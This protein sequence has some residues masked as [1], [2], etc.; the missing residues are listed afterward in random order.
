[1]APPRWV[2]SPPPPPP[3][4]THTLTC[5]LSRVHVGRAAPISL[6]TS[7]FLA[8][9]PHVRVVHADHSVFLLPPPPSVLLLHS[10]PHLPHPLFASSF[11]SQSSLTFSSPSASSCSV[12]RRY[13]HRVGRTARAGAPGS[14]HTLLRRQEVLHFKKLRRDID[15]KQVSTVALKAEDY[16]Q[17]CVECLCVIVC[18]CVCV[19][20]H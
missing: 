2:F 16:D 1:L 17:V 15:G 18:V 19:C 10:Y 12:V 9:L 3:T 7:P 6:A 5:A 4:H 11:A 8:L 20:V 14:A 13:V